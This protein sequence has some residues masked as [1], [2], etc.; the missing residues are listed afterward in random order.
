MASRLLT[1]LDADIAAATHPLKADC[2][3]AERAGLLARVGQLAEARQVLS[4]LQGQYANHP[5]AVMS[6]W[7]SLG[8]GLLCHFSDMAPTAHD[9]IRRA[10]ALSGAARDMRL[11][12]LTAAWLSL[13]EYLA[14]DFAGMAHHASEALRLAAP[15]DHGTRA[16]ASLVI[17]QGYHLSNRFDRAQ[18]WYARV[19]LHGNAEGDEATLSALMHNMAW[20]H[21]NLA[22]QQALSDPGGAC[23]PVVRPHVMMSAES[24]ANF[25]HLA[26][27]L[28]LDA[29]VPILRARILSL[30]GKWAESLALYDSHL[31]QAMAQGLGHM[32]ASLRADMAWCRAQLGQDSRALQD[33]RAAVVSVDSERDLD[34][35]AAAHSRLAQVFGKAGDALAAAR[36]AQRAADDWQAHCKDQAETVALLDAALDGIAP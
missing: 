8:E 18:P 34:D 7:L 5:H 30:Q 17:A 23:P 21:A 2:L 4:S 25:D 27:V 15:D 13:M 16:R 6:A 26:G 33:A 28:V 10:Y 12:A 31:S 11:H 1:R 22:R 36:H 29:L 19:R 24:T 35:R 3:R 32:Q 9:R 20:V 14:D